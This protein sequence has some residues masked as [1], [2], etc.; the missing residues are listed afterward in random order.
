MKAFLIMALLFITASSRSQTG[1]ATVGTQPDIGITQLAKASTIGLTSFL[2]CAP[3]CKISPI[4]IYIDDETVEES[5]GVVE[6]TIS[7]AP[8]SSQTVTVNFLTKNGSAKQPKDYIKTS[9][10]VQFLPGEAFKKITVPIVSDVFS[11]QEEAF[12]VELSQPVNAV[13]DDGTGKVTITDVP[14]IASR[15]SE[16]PI[17]PFSAAVV[18]NPS[19]GH[20]TVSISTTSF[21]PVK[22]QVYDAVGRLVKTYNE[23][24]GKFIR[25]GEELQAGVYTV[26]VMQGTKASTLKIIKL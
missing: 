10:T 1:V 24:D 25:I 22:L 7:I 26:K 12:F 5:K 16:Q 21:S 4:Q 9:G 20:F 3:S 14:G 15:G 13:I 2:P 23:M 17:I 8:S 11:E 19:A 18:P 6:L